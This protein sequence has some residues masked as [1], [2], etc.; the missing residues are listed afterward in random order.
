LKE[1]EEQKA[2]GWRELQEKMEAMN[3]SHTE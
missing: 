2:A 1:Q 3:L